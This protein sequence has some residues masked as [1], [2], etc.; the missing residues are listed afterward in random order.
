MGYRPQSCAG[1]A[2]KNE[3]LHGVVSSRGRQSAPLLFT[4]NPAT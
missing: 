1:T 2:G 4:A 3:S